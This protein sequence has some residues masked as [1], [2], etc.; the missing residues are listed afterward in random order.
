MNK[1][2]ILTLLV[3]LSSLVCAENP[4][5]YWGNFDTAGTSRNY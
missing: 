5:L 1:I 2:I 4:A 3:L